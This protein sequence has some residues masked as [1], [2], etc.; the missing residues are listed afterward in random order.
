[1]SQTVQVNPNTLG[2]KMYECYIRPNLTQPSLFKVLS[3][4]E[5]QKYQSLFSSAPLQ[6]MHRCQEM[7]VLCLWQGRTVPCAQNKTLFGV[8]RTDAGFCCSFNT[9]SIDEQLWGL[10]NAE[11]I[12]IILHIERKHLQFESSSSSIYPRILIFS[13]S[14]LELLKENILHSFGKNYF[15][16]LLEYKTFLYYVR[17]PTG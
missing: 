6:V 10:R 13:S 12:Q 8:Q 14:W 15:R 16:Q 3:N 4:W 1:M 17:R 7:F 9:I 2:I 5:R 11:R